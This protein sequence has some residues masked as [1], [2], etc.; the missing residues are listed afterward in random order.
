M[1]VCSCTSTSSS[2]SGHCQ[3]LGP[4]RVLLLPMSQSHVLSSS[5]N[6][7]DLWFAYR[8]SDQFSYPNKT[9][10]TILV[11]HILTS[12]CQHTSGIVT[13]LR[14]S[15]PKIQRSILTGARDFLL[16]PNIVWLWS[17][18][19]LLYIKGQ[20]DIPPVLGRQVMKLAIH[21]YILLRLKCMAFYLHSHMSSRHDD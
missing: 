6:T 16:P 8:T 15:L 18:G 20:W 14:L 11:L 4:E 2:L 17:T 1:S 21:F 7:L 3:I 19:R 5:Q 13:K 10:G 9:R 12:R